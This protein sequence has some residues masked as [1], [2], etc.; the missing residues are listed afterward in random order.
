MKSEKSTLVHL[1]VNDAERP[2]AAS[3]QTSAG[4]AGTAP[5]GLE[6]LL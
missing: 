4:V 2:S 3:E 1:A 5:S 6:R